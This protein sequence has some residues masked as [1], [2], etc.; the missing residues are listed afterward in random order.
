MYGMSL[1]TGVDGILPK[2]EEI[3]ITACHL[4]IAATK[5]DCCITQMICQAAIAHI[6]AQWAKEARDN[7]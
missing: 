4:L 6:T 2:D 5:A 1:K 3:Y 7:N